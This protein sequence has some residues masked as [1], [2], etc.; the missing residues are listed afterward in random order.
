VRGSEG[1]APERG[2]SFCPGIGN[3]HNGNFQKS[4]V[5]A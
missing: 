4:G 1:S 3:G 2:L 5:S